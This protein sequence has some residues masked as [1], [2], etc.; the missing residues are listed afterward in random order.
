MNFINIVY[1]LNKLTTYNIRLIEYMPFQIYLCVINFNTVII[2]LI[3]VYLVVNE[4]IAS[5]AKTILGL[6]HLPTFKTDRWLVRLSIGFIQLS[7]IS[8]L[9]LFHQSSNLP[10]HSII[11]PLK[12]VLHFKYHHHHRCR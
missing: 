1:T 8:G 7:I 9:C 12:N 10:S 5:K 3:L 2:P 4:M 11:L 6:I